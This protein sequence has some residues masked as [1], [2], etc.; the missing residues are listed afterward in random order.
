MVLLGAG[1]LGLGIQFSALIGHVTNAVPAGYAADISGVTTTT[2]QIGA[3]IGVA[4]RRRRRARCR[5]GSPSH[6]LPF[7]RPKNRSAGQGGLSYS[8][9]TGS[10]TLITP[11]ER[12]DAYTQRHP[13]WACA[14]VRST[15]RSRG[16]S[17]W[18]SVGVTHQSVGAKSVSASS[19]P[20]R[21]VRPAHSSSMNPLRAGA[22][23][24]IEVG[25]EA[26]A[27]CRRGCALQRPRWAAVPL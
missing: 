20:T 7:V 4:A 21:S 22:G 25:P 27:V 16:S 18:A 26:A 5:R 2:L 24:Q 6:S 11:G 15:L 10:P 13:P 12:T 3:A 8:R 23:V 17:S 14:A 9:T 1:G 19:S